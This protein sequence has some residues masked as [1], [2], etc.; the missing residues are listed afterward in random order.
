MLIGTK[1]GPA[2]IVGI[3]GLIPAGINFGPVEFDGA[4]RT[5]SGG[6]SVDFRKNSLR[7]L[8]GILGRKRN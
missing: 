2:K 1:F 5:G 8:A 4:K 6:I 3:K 7:A